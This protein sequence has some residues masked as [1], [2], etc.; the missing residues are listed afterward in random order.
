[1]NEGLDESLDGLRMC[2]DK[3]Y[4]FGAGRL[5]KDDVILAQGCKW[6][7][8]KDL[9]EKLHARELTGHA[10]RDAQLSR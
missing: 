7:V 8:F 1:M 9:A 4:T 5:T 3:L 6:E 2:L 10:A